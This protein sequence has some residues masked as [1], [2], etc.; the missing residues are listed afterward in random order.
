MGT[1]GQ[2]RELGDDFKDGASLKVWLSLQAEP[3]LSKNSYGEV[4]TPVYQN[5]TIF[6]R[7]VFIEESK[8]K[9]GPQGPN[10]MTDYERRKFRN[11]H[12][13]REDAGRHREDG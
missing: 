10:P 7:R 9:G 13:H 3:Y 12:I 6:R 2:D 5:V 8:L 1:Q 4:L 11:R